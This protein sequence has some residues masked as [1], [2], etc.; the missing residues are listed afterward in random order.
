MTTVSIIYFSASGHTATFAEAVQN[1]AATVEGV[2][3]KLVAI[4]GD[5]IVKGRYRNEDVMRTLDGSDAIVFGSPTFMGG[6]AAQFTA[7]ADASIS[8]WSV[9]RWR[10]KLAA[11]FTTS[12]ALS[13]DKFSTLEYFHTLAMQ[14]GMVW[15]GLGELPGQDNGV[16]RLGSWGGAMAQASDDNGEIVAEDK[17]T[18][19]ALGRR[20]AVFAA[21]LQT[22]AAGA[23]A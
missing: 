1:G 7:F 2:R 9:Q 11:G 15:I 5:D 18:G 21:T 19:E 16:N 6:P 20:V 10:D 3:I 22:V 17:L 12:G 14:H 8:R 13:G 4:N 23:A